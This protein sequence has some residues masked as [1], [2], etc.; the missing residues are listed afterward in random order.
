MVKINS[1]SWWFQSHHNVGPTF[2]SIKARNIYWERMITRYNRLAKK[3]TSD[4]FDWITEFRSY[5]AL[6]CDELDVI[7]DPLGTLIIACC[8]SN[9]YDNLLLLWQFNQKRPK[10]VKMLI[11]QVLPKS[12]FAKYLDA[13]IDT[14]PELIQVILKNNVYTWEMIGWVHSEMMN[15][16]WHRF[17]VCSCDDNTNLL[18]LDH[19]KSKTT[20]EKSNLVA[21]NNTV[22][23]ISLPTKNS[24]A[25]IPVESLTCEFVVGSEY[26][27]VSETG[28]LVFYPSYFHIRTNKEI[29]LE[30]S[31]EVLRWNNF[32][33]SN[34][35]SPKASGYLF[36]PQNQIQT[37][38]F[39]W[40]Q[41]IAF[42][43][44]SATSLMFIN[45]D[46]SKEYTELH[47]VGVLNKKTWITLKAVLKWETYNYHRIMKNLNYFRQ[48]H[49]SHFELNICFQMDGKHKFG[50]CRRLL[51]LE[52]TKKLTVFDVTDEEHHKYF[53]GANTGR[54]I[55]SLFLWPNRW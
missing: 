18:N 21:V 6:P 43:P 5:I 42:V 15:S 16:S 47:L 36:I 20:K 11:D 9:F 19:P 23:L 28:L 46:L 25:S 44:L 32:V 29:K 31:M 13:V 8:E 7:P 1:I 49:I 2:Q 17:D 50:I 14:Q 22:V 3:L 53:L 39:D 24:Y 38:V 51:S 40:N 26:F 4:K 45:F 55:R 37:A 10:Y 34:V 12:V 48:A 33:M 35:L 30:A 54:L 52:N 41:D 27:S